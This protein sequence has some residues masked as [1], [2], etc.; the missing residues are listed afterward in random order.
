MSQVKSA[1]PWFKQWQSFFLETSGR[2][3]K[4]EIDL[5]A[6]GDGVLGV[7][8]CKCLETAET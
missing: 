4:E 8:N 7:D 6:E 5:L 3:T 1:L 2:V